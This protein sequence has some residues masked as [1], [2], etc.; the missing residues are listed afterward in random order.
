VKVHWATKDGTA[1]QPADYTASAGDLIIKPGKTKTSFLVPT[2]VDLLD[3]VNEAFSV[4]LSKPSGAKVKTGTSTGTI[5]DGNPPPTA[6]VGDA[7]SVAEGNTGTA[8]AT[9]KVTLSEA[10]GRQVTVPYTTVAGTASS[11]SDYVAASD[12]LT[13]PAGQ[14]QADVTVNVNGDTDE[15]SSETFDL[16]IS[17]DPS[18][19]LGDAAGN[20]TIGNDD[21]SEDIYEQNDAWGSST[22]LGATTG[23]TAIQVTGKRCQSDDDYFG[24]TMTDEPGLCFFSESHTAT[25]TLTF[26]HSQGDLDMAVRPIDPAGSQGTSTSAGTE[27]QEQLSFNYS[28]TCGAN[29]DRIFYVRVYGY[30]DGA[31]NSYTLSAT[32]FEVSE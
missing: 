30:P 11:P 23:T 10:S 19:A 9:F 14:T 12:S 3:E 16:Q 25:I 17:A 7:G 29:D 28:G 1:V 32:H 26:A 4:S 31:F 15:E 8:P 6:S 5:T 13:I 18:L 27:N 2:A 24:V 20:A 21:C 22:N